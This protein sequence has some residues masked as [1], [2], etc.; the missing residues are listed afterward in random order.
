MSAR[1]AESGSSSYKGGSGAAGGLGNGGIGG[2]MGG[3]GNH[4]G[5]YGGGAGRNGGMASGTGLTTGN[6]W[7]GNTAFGQA[8]GFARGYAMRD[9]AS[10]RNAGMGPTMGSYS[11][12]NTLNGQ[13]MFNGALSGQSFAAPNANA[14]YGGAAAQYAAMMAAKQNQAMKPGVNATGETI[15]QIED[16]PPVAPPNIPR[17]YVPS[18]IHQQ[19][20]PNYEAL[21]AYQSAYGPEYMSLAGAP[22]LGIGQWTR[23]TNQINNVTGYDPGYRADTNMTTR[24]PGGPGGP[25][26]LSGGGGGW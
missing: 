25:S 3:G 4:G 8:G 10:L 20:T 2:G 17:S 13:P 14:A 24:Q 9:P 26:G 5:G 18:R 15:L 22:K 7:Y 12:F 19:F 21:R 16:V 1:D 6:N 11:N 23:N